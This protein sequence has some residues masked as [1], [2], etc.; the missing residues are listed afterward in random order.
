M[1]ALAKLTPKQERY[2]VLRASGIPQNKA[3]R[4][5]FNTRTT[6]ENV[7][8]VNAHRLEKKTKITLRI[9]EHKNE[10][11]EAVKE[12]Y[13]WNIQTAMSYLIPILN[14]INDELQEQHDNRTMGGKGMSP[15]LAM[16]W[17]KI[18]K[19]LNRINGL[20]KPETIIAMP[21]LYFGAEHLSDL[22]DLDPSEIQYIS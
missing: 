21:K 11:K 19:E 20:D 4:M 9:S 13:A 2:S 7:I 3:Y 10:F 12:K 8:S 6:N 5:S 22:D 18:A 15:Y 14:C 1:S 16:A 17:F